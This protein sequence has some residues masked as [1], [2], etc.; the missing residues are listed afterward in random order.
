MML[1]IIHGKLKPASWNSYERAYKE[2][3]KKARRNLQNQ[4]GTGSPTLSNDARCRIH[5]EPVGKRGGDAHVRKWRYPA[6][7][8]PAAAETI[9]LW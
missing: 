4:R 1:R 9:L 6:E 2:S 3:V 8:H 5:D 7:D